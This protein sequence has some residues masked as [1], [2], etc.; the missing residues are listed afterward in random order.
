MFSWQNNQPYSKAMRAS[1]HLELIHSDICG[2]MNMKARHGV[3]YFIT[4]IDDYS[5]YGY[6]C[7]LSHRYETL[8]VFK[9]FV[10]EVKTQLERRVKIL[11]TDR[12]REYLSDMFKEFSE[13]ERERRGIRNSF[14]CFWLVSLI[15]LPNLSLYSYGRLGFLPLRWPPCPSGLINEARSTIKIL[16]FQEPMKLGMSDM[17]GRSNS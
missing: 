11:W 3:I 6:V 2:P 8:N 16:L 7:L 10:A 1:S 9:R 14:Y 12:G 4:L 17:H 13:R 15:G 5:W